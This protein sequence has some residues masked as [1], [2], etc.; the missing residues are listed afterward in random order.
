M[1]K[2][3]WCLVVTGDGLASLGLASK[4]ARLLTCPPNVGNPAVNVMPLAVTHL[5]VSTICFL[6]ASFHMS[7][8]T[9]FYW[10]IICND[11]FPYQWP[12][13]R[14]M[15]WFILIGKMHIT[16]H[17][18]CRFNL[19][20][21]MHALSRHRFPFR[22]KTSIR[23]GYILFSEYIFSNSLRRVPCWSPSTGLTISD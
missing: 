14:S 17:F 15:K 3:C 23:G 4:T 8:L 21:D 22:V 1:S 12:K 19:D 7:A 13:P 11:Q 2:S 16:H 18:T 20:I 9:K 6:K 10:T 5:F